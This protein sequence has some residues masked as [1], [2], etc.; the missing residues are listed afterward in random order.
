MTAE[1]TAPDP[2]VPAMRGAGMLAVLNLA[3]RLTGFARVVV[4]A[5]ALGIVALGDTYQAA[6]L[7]SNVLFELLAGGLLFSVLVPTFVATIDRDG[8]DA[9]RALAGVLTARVLALLAVV[10]VAGILLGHVIMGWLTASTGSEALR[11]QQVQLG[12]YLLW[13]VM[14]Q[15]LLYAVGAITTAVLQADRRF[16]AAALAPICNNVVVIATM[17]AFA[18]VHDPARG[19]R[20][21]VG[22]ELLLG[23]GTL[24]GT[25]AMTILPM[26]ATRR[27]G[28]GF[29]PRWSAPGVTGLGAL[30]RKGAW[31]AG[32][33]G[34]N[35][36]MVT[37]TVIFA[38]RTAGGVIA[39]QTAF[40][41]FLL[42]H[43]VLA[44]P[45]FTTLFPHLATHG[46]AG[47]R[48]A[49]ARDLTDGLRSMALLLVPSAA[50]L[51]AVA[52]PTLSV[53][54]LGQ[55]DEH[56]ASFVATVLAGYLVGLLGYSAFLLL[57]RAA[58]ALDDVRS[59]TMVYLWVTLVAVG[60]MWVVGGQVGGEGR[61]VGLGLVH[62]GAVSAGSL[63]LYL[64]LR[65]R[66]GRPVPVGGTALRA[67][68]GSAVAGAAALGLVHVIGWDGRAQ[69]IAAIGAAGVVGVG[70]YAAVLHLLGTPELGRVLALLRGRRRGRPVGVAG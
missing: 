45:V 65:R 24:G 64:R 48:D 33:I 22:E 2:P 20:L 21:T 58:Y 11:H 4:T 43:A 26:V 44:H 29:L 47:D 5:A 49:F 9:G 50:L 52:L 27:A 8:R 12:A 37:A 23:A 30:L 53:V 31:G 66:L 54:R 32:D 6:S 57:T 39:Y 35:Q 28:L 41:F 68:V 59:P 13:F 63:G 61:V 69:A 1:V 70:L 42:P 60:A 46:A 25:V 36:V 19:I 40:S 38:G 51:A 3:S 34:L 15:L 7:V 62:A 14:P 16:A 17:V 67:V 10:T 18:V 56:G 55:L